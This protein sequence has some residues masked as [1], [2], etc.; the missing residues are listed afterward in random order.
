MKGQKKKVGDI[1]GNS[2]E[3]E[4]E[5]TYEEEGQKLPGILSPLFTSCA[6]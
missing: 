1:R 2:E 5:V 4:K 6:R 3:A